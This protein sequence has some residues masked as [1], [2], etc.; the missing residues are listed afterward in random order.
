MVSPQ[1]APVVRI[2]AFGSASSP[3]EIEWGGPDEW[4]TARKAEKAI[5]GG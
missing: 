3:T 5:E 1:L 4:R 2:A